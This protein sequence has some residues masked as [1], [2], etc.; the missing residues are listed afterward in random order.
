MKK[1]SNTRGVL[2]FA[3]NNTEIDYFRL[4]VVNALLVQ[5]NLGIKNI[6]VVTDPHSLA[7]GEKTLGKRLI[8]KAINNIVVIDK[9]IQFKAKNQRLYKDTSHTA[10]YLPFYNVNRCDAY[11]IS[12]YDETILIDV[13]YLILSDTLNSCWGHNNELMMNWKFQDIMYERKDPSLNRL[14]DMGIT[15]YW[16]TVVYFR[17]TEYVES[18]FNIVKHVKDNPQYYKDL[19]KWHGTLYRNDFSF[20]IA[21]H[22]MSGFVDKGIPQLPTTLYKSFDTD[23]IHSAVDENTIVMYLEK[24]RSPGD[25]MLTK[26]Q[27]VDIH[28]MNKW[29]INRVSDNLLEYAK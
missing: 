28:I 18:F 17:K 19:Y 6:T 26:W 29:A 14:Y 9:D 5:K 13:D 25:F 23:D 7:Q 15:M 8:K 11:D 3:H 12:P 24:P 4:A 16:A 27:G 21:A 10:K 22:V 1:E 2:M 20:S